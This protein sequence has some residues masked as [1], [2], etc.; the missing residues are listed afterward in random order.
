LIGDRYSLTPGEWL[1]SAP[2]PDETSNQYSQRMLSSAL[3]FVK[4][5]P[6][7]ALHFIAAHFLHNQVSTLLTLPASAQISMGVPYLEPKLARM[8]EQCCSAE[9]YVRTLPYWSQWD[10]T[11]VRQS[12]VSLIGALFLISVGIAAA[13]KQQGALGLIPIWISVFYAV[14]NAL[15]RSSGWRFN[16]PVDWVALLYFGIG[17]TRVLSWMG[18]F[19]CNCRIPRKIDTET[20]IPRTSAGF[21]W[22]WGIFVGGVLF[23]VS[24]SIPVA[25]ALIPARY[26]SEGVADR[27]LGADLQS[28]GITGDLTEFAIQ[29]N[30]GL[31]SGR[32]LYPRYYAAG[33]GIPENTWPAFIPRDYARLGF[34]LVGP[35]SSGVV[36]ALEQPPVQFPHA[37]DVI[38]LAC[39][40]EEHLEAQIVIVMENPVLVLANKPPSGWGCASGQ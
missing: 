33:K 38:V 35:N 6:A 9:A 1:S 34:Y 39:D 32:A 15:V 13:W 8:W 17:L 21:S 27:Q 36:L 12:A 29:H 11:F 18:I 20:L 22:G 40:A 37:A 31:L 3:R 25:E 30:L 19:F 14:G 5:Y 24:L 28:I 4:E 16:L 2:W 7:E 23:L 26:A 10:G